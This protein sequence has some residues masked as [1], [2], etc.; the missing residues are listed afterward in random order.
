MKQTAARAITLTRYFVLTIILC[1]PPASQ[2][3]VADGDI[4]QLLQLA[5]ISAQVERF[6]ELIKAGMRQARLDEELIS[7]SDFS[8]ML[9]RT[10]DTILPAEILGE[11]RDALRDA[12]SEDDIEQL[13]AWYRSDLG[14]EITGL[15]ERAG[16]PEA[17]AQMESRAA[18]LLEDTERVALAQRIDRIVGATELTMSI[19]EYTGIAVFSALTLAL[20]PA[21]AE[22]E[23]ARFRK[24]M[25]AMRPLF[26]EP[27]E[28][29]VIVSFVYTYEPLDAAKLGKFE[30]FLSRP[31]TT[32]FNRTVVKGLGLGFGRS[33]DN[34]ARA[35]A[36]IFTHQE[37]QI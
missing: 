35:L 5:G 27:T 31:E 1:A 16:T 17:Y 11:V 9:I 30:A 34:W 22:L 6:P 25:A 29:M 32:R 19:Q 23:I 4:D 7:E 21:S 13:L 37:Q 26:R 36:Q 33:I 18:A 28:R 12:L 24:Q 10:D 20:R 2:A 3:E 8:T 15:E 14:R